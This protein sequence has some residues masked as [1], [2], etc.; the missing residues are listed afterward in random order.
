MA[1][2]I[3][4]WKIINNRRKSIIIEGELQLTYPKGVTVRPKNRHFPIFAFD[5]YRHARNFN[6]YDDRIVVKCEAVISKAKPKFYPMILWDNYHPTISHL[7]SIFDETVPNKI[8]KWLTEM[9]TGT[10][11][12]SSLTPL[13]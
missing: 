4:V 12:C 2:K 6:I 7:I 9:P 8:N 5:S 13:E 3:I 1:K 11:L 10:V